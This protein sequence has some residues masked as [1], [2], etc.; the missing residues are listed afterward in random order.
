LKAKRHPPDVEEIAM[1]QAAT[2]GWNRLMVDPR[3]CDRTLVPNQ[4]LASS[5]AY[6]PGVHGGDRWIVE[7]DRRQGGIAPQGHIDSGERNGLGG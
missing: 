2:L 3:A 7:D 1:L 6:Q 4:V 5:L